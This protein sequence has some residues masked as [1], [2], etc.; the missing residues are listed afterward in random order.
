MVHWDSESCIGP[1]A[2][3][4]TMTMTFRGGKFGFWEVLWSFLFQPL[5]WLL[6]VVT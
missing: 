4:Q 1:A 6:L 3:H 2:D 5:S